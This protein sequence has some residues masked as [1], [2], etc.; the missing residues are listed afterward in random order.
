MGGALQSLL[1]LPSLWTLLLLIPWILHLSPS[2]SFILSSFFLRPDMT[3]AVDWALSNNYLYHFSSFLF[4]SSFL[5]LSLAL[6]KFSS[7]L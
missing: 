2:L 4:L 3:F 5:S 7:D 1:L 6:S